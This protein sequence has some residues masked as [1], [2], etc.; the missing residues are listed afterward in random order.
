MAAALTLYRS[1]IGKKAIMAISGLIGIGFL[2]AAPLAWWGMNRY[3]SEFAYKI[4]LGP[5]LFLAGLGLTLL[6]AALTVGYRSL[7][8]ALINP[9][10]SLRSE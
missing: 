1:S 2:I 3:L 4:T 8:A 7:R 6:V 10:N 9:V 5:G